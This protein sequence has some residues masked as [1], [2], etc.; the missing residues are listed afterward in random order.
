[1][2]L[3]PQRYLTLAEIMERQKTH[4][5]RRAEVPLEHYFSLPLPTGRWSEPGFSCYAAPALRRRGEQTRV[6]PPDRWMVYA[7][8]SGLLVLY[9]KVTAVPY[10]QDLPA[11]PET[12]PVPQGG[13]AQLKEELAEIDELVERL[14]PWFFEGQSG[15]ADQRRQLAA[16]LRSH[17]PG[18]LGEWQR[19]LNSDFFGWL[20]A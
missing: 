15:D 17:Q 5:L 11:E 4:W 2:T 12:V 10:A 3:G 16:L 19:A 18:R 13:I 8:N 9:A 7:A 6:S 20:H 14:A 1:M